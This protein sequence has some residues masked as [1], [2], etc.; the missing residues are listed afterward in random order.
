MADTYRIERLKF[1]LHTPFT[2]ILIYITFSFLLLLLY[3]AEFI[4]S[5]VVGVVVDC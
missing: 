4:M 2:Y 5:V 1:N 3:V